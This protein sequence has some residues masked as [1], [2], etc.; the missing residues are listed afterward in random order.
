L[1]PAR[2]RLQRHQ[3]RQEGLRL[4][5]NFN[6]LNSSQAFAFNLFMPYFDGSAAD[7]R[8]LL[9][10]LGEGGGLVRWEPEAIVDLQEGT[11]VDALWETTAGG[12]TYCEAKLTETEF[13]AARRNARREAKLA[14]IY[15]P[16][17]EGRVDAQLLEPDTF[18]EFYQLMRNVWQIAHEPTDR[19]ILLVPREN[20]FVWPAIAALRKK[21]AADLRERVRGVAIEDVIASLAKAAPTSPE[22][23]GY[24]AALARKYLPPA[25]ALSRPVVPPTKRERSAVANRPQTGRA[26]D[27]APRRERHGR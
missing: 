23:A 14:T 7:A 9:E 8:V 20:E 10:A 6:H 21:L 2:I 3:A 17:L 25:E 18:F 16:A 24:G 27:A 1:P 22:L 19:L 5:K 11:N 15:R 26:A 4:H 13:A 12:V